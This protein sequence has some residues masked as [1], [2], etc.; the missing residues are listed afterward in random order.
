MF[1]AEWGSNKPAIMKSKNWDKCP[2]EILIST[3]R[4]V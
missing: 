2:S 3:P 4:Y 1:K